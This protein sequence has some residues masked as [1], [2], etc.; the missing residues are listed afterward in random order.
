MKGFSKFTVYVLL[1]VIIGGLLYVGI[2]YNGRIGSKLES[3]A[4][5]PLEKRISSLEKEIAA[6]AQTD[7][8]D[9]IKK[10]LSKLKDEVSSKLSQPDINPLKS[11]L[12]DLESKVEGL[13]SKL[14]SIEKTVSAHS[15]A[16]AKLWSHVFLLEGEDS[17]FSDQLA[18]IKNQ[19][20]KLEEKVQS[21]SDTLD[22]M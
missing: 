11:R 18:A 1:L 20:E 10:D 7:V 13:N 8:I 12:D 21:N 14:D 5:A 19:L 9:P 3:D 16:H 17:S 4:I 15:D 22:A 6:K 2:A